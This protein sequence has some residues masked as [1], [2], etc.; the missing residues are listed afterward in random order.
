MIDSDSDTSGQDVYVETQG[1]ASSDL[2]VEVI[3][4]NPDV[5][6]TLFSTSDFTTQDDANGHY[7]AT[8]TQTELENNLPRT[9]GPSQYT[10]QVVNSSDEVILSNPLELTYDNGDTV[11]SLTGDS[12]GTTGLDTPLLADG[13][14]ISEQDTLL[15]NFLTDDNTSVASMSSQVGIPTD[16]AN[17]ST[18]I[19]L[20]SQETRDAY[21]AAAADAEAG[22]Q[23]DAVASVNSEP[24]Q[25]FAVGD[26]APEDVEGAYLT[27]DD[28]DGDLTLETNGDENLESANTAFVT[29]T[30]GDGGYGPFSEFGVF[31]FDS[32]D[33][34]DF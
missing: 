4:A 24:V 28:T 6:T 3:P 16:P 8:L 17:A 29:S 1:A 7:S 18:V 27:Y 19:S 13:L 25:V 12:T 20:D 23:I 14:T 32:F 26:A 5:N 21:D 15:P 11:I 30:A 22:E 34:G 31:S 9:A 33:F 2:T 10:V